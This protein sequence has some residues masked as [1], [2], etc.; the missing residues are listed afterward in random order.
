MPA[1]KLTGTRL[2]AVI[3]LGLA[4]VTAALYWPMLR[5]DFIGY[6]DD[7]SYITD[8]PHVSAGLTGSG[9]AWAF[10]SGYAANWHP[11]TWLSHMLDCQLYGLNSGW[12]H[13]TSLLFHIANTLLLFWVLRRMTGKLWAS[14]FVA[15]LFALHPLHV[16][17]V[18]WVA[19]R[20]DVLST[21][22]W[23]LTLWAYLRYVEQPGFTRYLLAILFF[24]LGLL[25]KPMLVTLPFVLLLLDYWPLG[26]FSLGQGGV[27]SANAKPSPGGNQGSFPLHLVLEKIPF[28]ALAA[29]S[30]VITFV[31]QQSAEAVQNLEL[32]SVGERIGNALVSYIVYI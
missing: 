6:Y 30:S 31:A 29:V 7:A 13:L 19:E 2:S 25:S 24:V 1:A 14:S 18:A 10:R 5:H 11:L 12:H 26:R 23:M 21:F 20:K 32:F 27:H 9:I 22:F 3:C 28:F 16:E 4:L 17:S 15:A 8:N